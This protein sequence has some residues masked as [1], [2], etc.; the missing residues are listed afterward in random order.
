MYRYMANGS[1]LRLAD[2][3]VIPKDNDN[4]DYQAFLEWVAEGNKPQPA[5]DVTITDSTYGDAQWA[6]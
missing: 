2:G 6:F 1:I 3:A 4:K 5:I